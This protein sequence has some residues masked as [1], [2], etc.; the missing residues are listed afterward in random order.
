MHPVFNPRNVWNDFAIIHLENDFEL[1]AHI[2]VICLPTETDFEDFDKTK[3]VAT[4]W[5]KESMKREK[6]KMFWILEQKFVKTIAENCP[7]FFD[8]AD[9]NRTHNKNIW[10]QNIESMKYAVNPTF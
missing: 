6:W 5:G 9:K 4:S 1:D 8:L 10:H 3:C 2:N 7:K